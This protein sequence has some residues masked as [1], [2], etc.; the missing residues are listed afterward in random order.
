MS[1]YIGVFFM[2]N[3]FK[4]CST[5][6]TEEI[7]ES[8]GRLLKG[9]E[10]IALYGGLGMGKTAFVRGLAR[11]LNISADISSPTFAIVH[12][13]RGGKIL[14][15]FDMYRVTSWDDL[16]STGFFDYLNNGI[17]VTEWSENIESA[18]PKNAIK[19]EMSLGDSENERIIKIEGL[20]E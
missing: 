14:Y 15:H 5:E 19:I 18:I 16:Y 4:S 3:I 20:D 9:T 17:I 8:I 2:N 6:S 12:E 11:G 13:Y 7:G 1:D 10:V